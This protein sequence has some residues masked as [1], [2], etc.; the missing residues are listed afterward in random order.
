M[1]R[2]K[3]FDA[4]PKAAEEF[5]VRTVAGAVL[6]VVSAVVIVVLVVVSIISSVILNK[7]YSPKEPPADRT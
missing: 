1:E 6:S 4:Y 2:L 5:R 7:R 3:V